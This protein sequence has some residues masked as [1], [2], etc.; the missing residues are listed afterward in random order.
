MIRIYGEKDRRKP[1]SPGIVASDPY[2]PF[3]DRFRLLPEARP[4]AEKAASFI[5]AE[6]IFEWIQSE[7]RIDLLKPK[8]LM[9]E[10]RLDPIGTAC[11]LRLSSQPYY[12]A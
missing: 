9:C 10:F 11:L 3:E 2:R 1:P 5:V 12:L 7:I 4:R 8:S 6:R